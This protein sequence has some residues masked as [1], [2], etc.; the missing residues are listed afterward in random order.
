MAKKS[1]L[2]DKPAVLLNRFYKALLGEKIPVEKLILFGSYAKG[3]PKPWS[4]LDVCVVSEAFGKDYYDELV[5][6]KKLASDIEPL[7]EPYPMKPKDLEDK[8]DPLAH[9]VRQYGK[10][11]PRP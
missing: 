3:N 4:D 11:W 5:F 10:V 6:L 8:W 7:I 2:E 1:I 9:E